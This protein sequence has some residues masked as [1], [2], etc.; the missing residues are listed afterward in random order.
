VHVCVRFAK[1]TASRTDKMSVPSTGRGR[2]REGSVRVG[3]A[4]QRSP[5]QGS[6]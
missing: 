3:Y 4:L 1:R 6:I 2:R 5:P